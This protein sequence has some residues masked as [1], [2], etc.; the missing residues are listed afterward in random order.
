VSPDSEYLVEPLRTGAELTLYRGRGRSDPTPILGVA[1]AV[2]QPSPRSLRRLEHEYALANEL[3]AAWAARPLALTRHQGRAVLFLR[4][5]EG[6][7]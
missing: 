3:D 2:E 6:S 1:V 7:P 5:Q 4:T